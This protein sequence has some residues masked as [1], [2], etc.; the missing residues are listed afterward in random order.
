MVVGCVLTSIPKMPADGRLYVLP[1][2]EA[3]LALRGEEACGQRKKEEDF[4]E[5]A[6]FHDTSVTFGKS[7]NFSKHQQFFCKMRAEISMS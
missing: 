7:L 5:T 6:S 3:S 4:G 2:Q 1:P